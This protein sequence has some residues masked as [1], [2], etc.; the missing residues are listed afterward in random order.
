MDMSWFSIDYNIDVSDIIDI[1]K[2]LLKK[3]LK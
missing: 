3:H 1:H 2:N